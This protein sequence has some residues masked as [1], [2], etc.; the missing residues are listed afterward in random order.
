[1]ENVRLTRIIFTIS[2]LCSL[3]IIVVNCSSET[4]SITE[5]AVLTNLSLA[6]YYNSEGVIE[7]PT[8][9]AADKGV[10]ML[11][12]NVE[13]NLSYASPIQGGVQKSPFLFTFQGL[14]GSSVS[15]ISF[16]PSDL[17]ITYNE[18]RIKVY[19]PSSQDGIIHP[20]MIGA[21]S[22]K[23]GYPIDV[24]LHHLYSTLYVTLNKGNYS[25]K[26]IVFKGN[27]GEKVSGDIYVDIRDWSV[28]A[29]ED[30]IALDFDTPLD[31]SIKDQT[32]SLMVAPIFFSKGYSVEVID[33]K[34]NKFEITTDESISLEM[35]GKAY[36][37]GSFSTSSA[38]LIFCGDNMV[39][40][41]N[42]KQA[43][44]SSY[45]DAVT[46]SWDAKNA[47]SILGLQES[48][49][50]HLD[51][52]KLVDN[53]QKLLI[54]SSYGWTVLLDIN[55]KQVLFHSV[56]TANAHSAEMLP[57]NRIAVACSSGTG[58]NNN[59]IQVYDI[60][61]PN[62]ILYQTEL[63][64]AHGVIWNSETQRLYAIGDKFLQIYK[65]KDWDSSTP[66]I[67]LEKNI[68]T[69]QSGLHDITFVNT[70]TLCIAGTKAYL[71][72]IATETFT[73]MM[74]F[75]NSTS[76]K[77]LNYNGNTGEMW[78]TDATTPQGDYTW[79]T[80]MIH[81]ATDKDAQTATQAIMVPDVNIYKVRVKEW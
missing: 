64:S 13:N 47:A 32:I 73:E 59:K 36:T 10:L 34:N 11:A 39:Y 66:S 18:G 17:N 67:E 75:T 57:N 16:Y 22:G 81:Y 68:Q 8:W 40:M 6:Q 61:K 9:K 43:I 56:S 54:T 35:G 52:C 21:S 38:E 80:H 2:F 26:S 76:L 31:C 30:N 29:T 50:D 3:L 78:Y 63:A 1:M 74:H 70:K 42:A 62:V 7:S 4:E 65:L 37:N 48:R 24:T 33:T 49:C 79:S 27:N 71:F 51:D 19:L 15:L 53:N 41:I 72:N 45:S 14:K 46:W 44:E 25:A 77:S 69:P 28:T 20:Y 55:T 23:L 60:S 12:E 58:A 5:K